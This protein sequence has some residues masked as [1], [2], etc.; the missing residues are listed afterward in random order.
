MLLSELRTINEIKISD[1]SE[2]IKSLSDEDLITYW[3]YLASF[4]NRNDRKD[5]ICKQEYLL[6]RER[7]EQEADAAWYRDLAQDLTGVYEVDQNLI[8]DYS[9]VPP[10]GLEGEAHRE[11]LDQ[12][13]Q[14]E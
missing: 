11:W 9:Q 8:R 7:E 4:D 12:L 5:K 6:R 3:A 13:G 1:L 10:G 2:A 14:N